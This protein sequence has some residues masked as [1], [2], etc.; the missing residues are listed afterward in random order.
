MARAKQ[1]KERR[2]SMTA[3]QTNYT[4]IVV[5]DTA[6]IS[7]EEWLEYRR[8]GIGGSDASAVL[9]VSPFTTARDLYYDKLRIAAAYDDEDNWVQKAIGHLL[10]DLVAKI[11]HVKTGYRVYQIKKMFRH[12]LCHF[13]IADVDYFVEMP[14]GATAI[15]EIKTTNYN[16]RDKWWDGKDEIIPLNYELQGRHYM[17][18]MN[19]HRV[20]FCCLYGNNESEVVIRCK[21]R[22]LE[23]ESELIA[24]EKNF[25][26][27]HVQTQI[28]PP[29]TE[30]G[31]LV[32]ESVRR[33]HGAADPG[34]P[35]VLLNGDCAADIARYLELQ[36]IK[37]ELDHRGKAVDDQM[38]RIKGR[39][40]AEMGNNC[41]A[42]CEVG[43]VPYIVAYNPVFKT[44]IS[45]DH[46]AKLKERHPDIYGEYVTVSESRRFHLKQKERDAA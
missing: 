27:N 15:L 32:M 17:A 26:V 33:R 7:K 8:T 4:P 30:D 11:F 2:K 39:I 13:M 6:E 23:Y 46:L 37:R 10:E 29:Y 3:L 18:V 14:D 12:P 22:D 19:V 45:K 25:W 41:R 24:L 28:P 38:N 16:N 42:S 34:A 1:M 20:Y 40:V 44:G 31:D 35:E 21:D 36:D 5:A 43:G 9:G